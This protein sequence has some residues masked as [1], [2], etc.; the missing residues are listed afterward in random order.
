V[1]AVNIGDAPRVAQYITMAPAP[2]VQ[3]EASRAGRIRFWREREAGLGNA[4]KPA[5]QQTRIQPMAPLEGHYAKQIA[6][7]EPWPDGGDGTGDDGA[8]AFAG[9]TAEWRTDVAARL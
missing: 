6:G 5:G 1:A 8:G 7:V 2:E 3:D 4:D 9:L